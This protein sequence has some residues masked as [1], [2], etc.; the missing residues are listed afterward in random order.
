MYS[1]GRAHWRHMANTIEPSVCGGDADLCQITLTTFHVMS[2]A[3]WQVPRGLENPTLH[4][5]S[6]QVTI[7]SPSRCSIITR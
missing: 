5:L 7:I 2:S 6:F 1:Y 3:I 4:L